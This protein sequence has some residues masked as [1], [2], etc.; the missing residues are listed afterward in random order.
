MFAFLA[1]LR[2]GRVERKLDRAI[3]RQAPPSL[4]WL[5]IKAVVA[6]VLLVGL[7]RDLFGL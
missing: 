3:G 1:W 7:L 4:F 5:T 6:V 2:A